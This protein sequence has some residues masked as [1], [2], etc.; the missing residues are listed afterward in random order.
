MILATGLVMGF[1][2]VRVILQLSFCDVLKV[3]VVVD[4]KSILELT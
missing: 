3:L 2:V 4:K 1:H